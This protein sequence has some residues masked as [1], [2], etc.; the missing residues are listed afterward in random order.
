MTDARRGIVIQGDCLQVLRSLPDA[1]VDLTVFS[2]P[3]DD[4]R[5]YGG[6]WSIDLPALGRELLR[7][8]VDGGMVAMVIQDSTK[9][10]AKTG[11]TFRTFTA[12]MEAGWRL[13][14]CLI[15]YRL[16]TPG[17]W[18]NERFRV[19]HEYVGVFLKG[20]A[21]RAFD[22]NSVMVP[23]AS[24][25]QERW[26]HSRAT[27]GSLTPKRIAKQADLRCR[28]TVW[29]INSR[30]SGD[31]AK[32]KH[33]ATYPDNLAADL[34]TCFS[35]PGDHVLDPMCGSGTTCRMAQRLGRRWTGVD[36]NQDYCDIANRL[37]SRDRRK[38]LGDCYPDS[39]H[40]QLT[41]LGGVHELTLPGL[42]AS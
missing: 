21:P 41:L 17:P 31:T 25:G 32:H 42:E 8:T 7:L 15:Y 9:D 39:P 18:W 22:K 38:M 26:S 30:C 27:N 10:R 16:G 23:A 28:G 3:Y 12:W 13:W 20:D 40:Q 4:I 33:P 34:I 1:S 6:G 36:I 2:P 19:D 37:L 5:N 29:A 11:T 14:E 35:R 24:A